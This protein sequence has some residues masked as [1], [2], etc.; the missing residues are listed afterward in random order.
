MSEHVLHSYTLTD[1]KVKARIRSLQTEARASSRCAYTWLL[2]PGDQCSFPYIAPPS[3]ALLARAVR[4]P[5]PGWD[6]GLQ[7]AHH[8]RSCPIRPVVAGNGCRVTT[9]DE[10]HGRFPR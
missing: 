4:L 3:P 6:T 8:C 5:A 1:R 10:P 7:I 9:A 2:R